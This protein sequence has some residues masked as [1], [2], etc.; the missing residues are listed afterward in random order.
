MGAGG[1]GLSSSTSG[2]HGKKVLGGPSSSLGQSSKGAA[3]LTRDSYSQQKTSGS[4]LRGA[5][6]PLSKPAAQQALL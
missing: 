3:A 6:K 5:S 1:K 4:S 2:I